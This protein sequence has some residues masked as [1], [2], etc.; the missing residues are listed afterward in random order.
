MGAF[1]DGQ[2]NIEALTKILGSDTK[3]PEELRTDIE[4]CI[5][6]TKTEDCQKSF[7]AFKCFKQKNLYKIRRP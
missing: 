2:F 1:S 6:D 3:T 7:A 5:D 4:G